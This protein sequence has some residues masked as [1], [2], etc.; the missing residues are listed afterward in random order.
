M[1]RAG[2]RVQDRLYGIQPGQM[3]V[4]G[5]Y[6]RLWRIDSMS[7]FQHFILH[8]GEIIPAVLGLQVD[9][10]GFPLPQRVRLAS[11]EPACL[12]LLGDT[13]IELHQECF[14]RDEQ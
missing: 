10:A 2:H 13:E 4:V 1:T 12:L 11:L 6:H 8:V 5:T 3:L 9:L 14:F 7:A